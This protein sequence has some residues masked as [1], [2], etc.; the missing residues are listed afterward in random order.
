MPELKSTFVALGDGE[1]LK[2][3]A[4][5]DSWLVTIAERGEASRDTFVLSP[6]I[7]WLSECCYGRSASI[8]DRGQRVLTDALAAC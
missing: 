1:W 8:C 7:D 4:G 2:K 5:D 6:C 3:P